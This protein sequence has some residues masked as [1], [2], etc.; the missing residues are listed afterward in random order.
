MVEPLRGRVILATG[1]ANLWPTSAALALTFAILSGAFFGGPVNAEAPLPIEEV[2]ARVS[3]DRMME[4]VRD[5]ESF[6]SRAFY[7]NSS[8]DAAMYISDRFAA[9]GLWVTLQ[10]LEVDGYSVPNVIGVKNGTGGAGE[11]YLFGAHYD[12]VNKDAE[13]NTIGE[14]LL[15]PGADDD[16]SG[17]AAVIE[18]ATL[19]KDFVLEHTL[20]FVAF[21]AEESGLN[22]SRA[23]V[24]AE[25]AAGAAYGDTVIFDMIGYR[26]GTV[27]KVMLFTDHPDETFPVRIRQVVVDYGID[28]S[29]DLVGRADYA[30]SDQ[31]S[32]WQQGYPTT[33][34]LEEFYGTRPVNPYYHTEHDVSEHLCP[35]QMVAVSQAVLGALLLLEQ[36]EPQRNPHSWIIAAGS[37]T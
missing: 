32:F 23:F 21:G 5:L 4:S 27:N 29:I 1:Q 7:V 24:A 19:T 26:N 17:I 33:A 6:G 20:K 36:S 18:I 37:V 10:Y 30:F 9:I 15:A 25:R 14:S 13:N 22:G 8:L 16:A 34:I 31:Y 28:L 2:L 12:S 35:E 11:M 3:A